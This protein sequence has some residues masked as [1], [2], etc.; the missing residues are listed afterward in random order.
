MKTER[1]KNKVEKKL[2]QRAYQSDG[3]CAQMAAWV[4]I[5]RGKLSGCVCPGVK[6]IR[7]VI[8]VTREKPC[9][10]RNVSV[11]SSEVS[12]FASVP[13]RE[14]LPTGVRGGG[15]YS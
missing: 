4:L 13:P 12:C 6:Q 14:S 11:R 9:I 15:S 1:G 2:K 7:C 3:N 10:A 5:A 8:T